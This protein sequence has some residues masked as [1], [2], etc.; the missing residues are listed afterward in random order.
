MSFT[1]SSL[2]DPAVYDHPVDNIRLVETHISWIILTGEI[3]YKI[4]K[5]VNYGFLNFST[6]ENRKRDCEQELR[7]NQRMAA[8]IYLDVVAITGSV[9][10]PVIMHKQAS[11]AFEYA[12]K[13]VQFP[14]SA[15]LDE[16]LAAGKLQQDHM[17]AIARLVADFHAHAAVA[18]NTSPYGEPETVYHPVAENMA[19]I[20]ENLPEGVHD[21]TITSLQH[22]SETTFN[23]LREQIRQRKQQGWVRECHGDLHLRNMLWLDH[24]PLAFDCI[25]FN[26]E[27]RWIDVISDIAFLVMDLQDRQAPELANRFLNHY[28]EITGDYAGLSLLRFYRCYRAM[29]RAKVNALRLQQADLTSEEKQQTRRELSSYLHLA[30][31]IIQTPSPVLTIM[32]GVSASGKSTVSSELAQKTGAIRIRSD[33]ERKRL[34]N[35]PSLENISTGIDKGFYSPAASSQTYAELLKLATQ[36][37]R[38]G[39]PVIVDAAFLQEE[40][41]RLFQ[42]CAGQ[43]AVPYQI[44]QVMAPADV[45]RQRILNREQDVSDA[46]L[47]VLENQLAQWQ[48]L[49]ADEIACAKIVD[50][51]QTLSMQDS[52]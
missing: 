18:D 43:L 8:A 44:V 19:L 22:W 1:L 38:A 33:V 47:S 23:R 10:Q 41:R 12:V 3:A 35:K 17:D 27:L 7:L 16:R 9:E 13:M 40:Q 5:P 29:V 20:R 45:L 21:R 26:A 28:L 34:F 48:P 6:L 50:T 32:R 49:S 46:N 39:Y 15:H 31:E 14:Q 37:L 51:T 36:V 2:L 52:E 4:K 25:E 30:S 24:K 11:N 42:Q